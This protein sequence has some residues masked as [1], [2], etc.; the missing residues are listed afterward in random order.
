MLALNLAAVNDVIIL[1]KID[2]TDK[3]PGPIVSVQAK[4]LRLLLLQRL[5]VLHIFDESE[6]KVIKELPQLGRVRS[7]VCPLLPTD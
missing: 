3:R 1:G 2:V 4:M 5:A 6:L 7:L